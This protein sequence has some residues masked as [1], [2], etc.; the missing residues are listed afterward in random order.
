MESESTLAA[1]TPAQAMVLLWLKALERLP[2]ADW[3]FA[4]PGERYSL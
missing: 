4:C 1:A 2:A 3:Y